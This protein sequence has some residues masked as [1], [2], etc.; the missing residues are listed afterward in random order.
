MR[1]QQFALVA[2]GGGRPGLWL[3]RRRRQQRSAM[4]APRIYEYV[5]SL[6]AGARIGASTAHS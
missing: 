3:L 5:P 1:S 2:R 6:A 4:T